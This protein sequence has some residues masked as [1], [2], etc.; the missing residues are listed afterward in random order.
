[1][2]KPTSYRILGVVFLVIGFLLLG[3]GAPDIEF[4]SPKD[5]T[6]RLEERDPR[7]PVE[8]AH[9]CVPGDSYGFPNVYVVVD[10]EGNLVFGEDFMPITCGELFPEEPEEH[11]GSLRD[12]IPTNVNDSATSASPR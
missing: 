11:N 9:L 10:L 5:S 1:M 3:L 12:G 2:V 6:N 4:A 8:P 7:P